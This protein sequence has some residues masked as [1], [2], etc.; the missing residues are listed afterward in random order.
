MRKLTVHKTQTPNSMAA[1]HRAK[2]PFVVVFNFVLISLAKIVPSLSLK[3][4]LLRLSGMKVGRNVSIGLGAMFDIFFPELITLED[5]CI[6]GYNATVLAHEFLL[7]EY[8]TG[9]VIIGSST[10]VGA[11]ST[12]LPGITIG[13]NAVVSACSLVNRDVKAGSFVGGVPIREIE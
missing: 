12:I 10:L 5:N 1:W 11:N 6:I 7:H 13:P 4:S 2:N 8:R 3:R 9:A